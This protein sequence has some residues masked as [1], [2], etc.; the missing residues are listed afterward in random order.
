[1]AETCASELCENGGINEKTGEVKE[2]GVDSGEMTVVHIPVGLPS[3]G[4]LRNL[5]AGGMR[6]MRAIMELRRRRCHMPVRECE[7][8]LRRAGI[9]PEVIA[10]VPKVLGT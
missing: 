9:D 7:A 1:M 8:L 2:K 5:Q 6:A 4:L 3:G 10:E